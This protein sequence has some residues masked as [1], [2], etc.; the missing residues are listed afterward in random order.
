MGTQDNVLGFPD[1]LALFLH[2]RMTFLPWPQPSPFINPLITTSSF[3]L[4]LKH[5]SKNPL[6]IPSFQMVPTTFS[7]VSYISFLHWSY[8]SQF[9]CLQGW[10]HFYSSSSLKA[11]TV[12]DSL[13]C[14]QSQSQS[15]RSTDATLQFCNLRSAW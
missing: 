4:P 7:S 3:Q 6:L 11:T 8:N 10:L 14:T 5:C 2:L 1:S 13:R 12:S 15:A 9:M